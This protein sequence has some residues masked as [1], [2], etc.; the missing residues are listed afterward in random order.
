MPLIP[1]LPATHKPIAGGAVVRFVGQ[2]VTGPGK[3]AVMFCWDADAPPGSDRITDLY[4]QDGQQCTEV[5]VR[6]NTFYCGVPKTV[7]H[8]EFSVGPTGAR[9]PGLDW[10]QLEQ[11][12]SHVMGDDGA[13]AG[14]ID[15]PGSL[16]RAAGDGVWVPQ[17]AAPADGDALVWDAA[18]SKWKPGPAGNPGLEGRVTTLETNSATL[19]ELSH[20]LILTTGSITTSTTIPIH[21]SM[22]RERLEQVSMAFGGAVAASD[23]NYWQVTFTRRRVSPADIVTKTSRAVTSGGDGEPISAFKAW[24]FAGLAF[25]D[26]AVLDAGDVLAVTLTPVG[27][28]AALVSPV[29]SFRTTPT[30]A[31]SPADP[32]PVT[33]LLTNSSFATNTTGWAGEA[34]T[35]SRV[36]AAGWSGTGY[37]NLLATAASGR[38]VGAPSGSAN[39]IPVT[40]GATYTVSAYVKSTTA[41][42]T[43]RM[44]WWNRDSG[45]VFVSDQNGS[46]ALVNLTT[47]W[48]RI[49]YTGVIPAGVSFACP[50]V[51]FGSTGGASGDSFDVDAF[52]FN[53]GALAPYVD[54]S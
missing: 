11:V 51:S 23:T 5:P 20:S 38:A 44:S 35:L 29:V 36:A 15:T 6:N 3:D 19:E 50:R 40:V 33:N 48:Q 25:A 37:A 1:S 49:T 16:T 43:A 42:M 2:G 18:S 17:P 31:A 21:A 52:M 7:A 27:S 54:G 4:D 13:I 32:I 47:S 10:E 22:A 41:G 45:G 24:G 26:Y 39:A 34:G 9:F 8:P 14:Q 28:P 53:A 46:G 30:D 12:A